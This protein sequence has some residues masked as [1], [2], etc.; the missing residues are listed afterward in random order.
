ML[1]PLRSPFSILR[2]QHVLQ[3][4]PLQSVAAILDEASASAISLCERIVAKI[5]EIKKIF[6][7]PPGTSQK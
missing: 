4:L 7:G 6:L 5:N 2:G 3:S 1:P